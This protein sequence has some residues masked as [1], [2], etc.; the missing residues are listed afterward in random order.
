MNVVGDHIAVKVQQDSFSQDL[1]KTYSS[2]EYV[3]AHT[4]R[5]AV[6]PKIQLNI[7]ENNKKKNN[8][9]NIVHRL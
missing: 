4:V 1:E 3:K 2:F 6:C 7:Q 9:N 5:S 8:N